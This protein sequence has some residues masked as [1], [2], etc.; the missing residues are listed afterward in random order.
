MFFRWKFSCEKVF[1]RVFTTNHQLQTIH[2]DHDL[3]HH[4]E[5]GD[6]TLNQWNLC[7]MEPVLHIMV[8]FE[9]FLINGKRPQT[10]TVTI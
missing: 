3:C 8:V 4:L 9:R 7:Q 1:F 6:E 2:G 10:T 5:F